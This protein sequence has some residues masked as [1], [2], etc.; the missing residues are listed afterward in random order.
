VKRF[1]FRLCVGRLL[2]HK[3]MWI[4]SCSLSCIRTRDPLLRMNYCVMYLLGKARNRSCHWGWVLL[5]LRC[6]LRSHSL[7]DTPLRTGKHGGQV[8]CGPEI[9]TSFVQRHI[10]VVLTLDISTLAVLTL[11]RSVPS[12]LIPSCWNLLWGFI[13]LH[14]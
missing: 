13:A 2:Q 14:P 3:G 12:G 5:W 4:C 11:H 7:S 1:L 6:C 8:S 9:G 10:S